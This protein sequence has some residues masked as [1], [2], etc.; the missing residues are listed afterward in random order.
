MLSCCIHKK[1]D[2]TCIRKMIRKYLNLKA[3]NKNFRIY[4]LKYVR[5]I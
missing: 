2:Q 1:R 5:K 3:T 4:K